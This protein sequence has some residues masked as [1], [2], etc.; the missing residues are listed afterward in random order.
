MVQTHNVGWTTRTIAEVLPKKELKLHIGLLSPG[1]LHQEEEPPGH[2]ALKANVAF[3][4]KTQR[5]VENRAV[6]LKG[7]PQNFTPSKTQGRSSHLK[8]V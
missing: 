7:H 5:D 1:L 3:F 6:T 8:E 4:H 2:L